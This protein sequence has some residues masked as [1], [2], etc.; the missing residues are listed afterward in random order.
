MAN[1]IAS[2]FMKSMGS[3]IPG[4]NNGESKLSKEDQK[5][6]NA[7]YMYKTITKLKA[8]EVKSLVNAILDSMC[9]VTSNEQV[10]D[11]PHPG[12]ASPTYK[13]IH[14]LA[15]ELT[16]T[17]FSKV[18]DQLNSE[19]STSN[20]QTGGGG[21][22]DGDG[23]FTR[24]AKLHPAVR[25]ASTALGTASTALK[26]AGDMKNKISGAAEKA[27]D[28]IDAVKEKATEVVDTT[29]N[30]TTDAVEKI[31]N[32][33]NLDIGNGI[34]DTTAKQAKDA[35]NTAIQKTKSA[36]Q[37]IQ[38]TL[39]NTDDIQKKFEAT[40]DKTVENTKG[41]AK[42]IQNT[43]V[44]TTGM[45]D[46]ITGV[47]KQTSKGAKDVIEETAE[48]AKVVV[49]QTAEDIANNAAA[50]TIV[51]EGGEKG[52]TEDDEVSD[53]EITEDEVDDDDKESD[54][55]EKTLNHLRKRIIQTIQRG[56]FE[57]LIKSIKI[58]ADNHLKDTD[59]TKKTKFEDIMKIMAE[60]DIK[61]LESHMEFMLY[62]IENSE[63]N[64][65]IDNYISMILVLKHFN[66]NNSF[67]IDVDL[68]KYKLKNDLI[69][70]DDFNRNK[71]TYLQNSKSNLKK[72]GLSS[73][74]NIKDN[75]D[76]TID[77]TKLTELI[78]ESQDKTTGGTRRYKKK[79]K[80][81]TKRHKPKKH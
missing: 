72:Y 52:K 40:V 4:N 11:A 12:D 77:A 54:L 56:G 20:E 75:M 24:I 47:I 41:I 38:K 29:S 74:D 45:K 67:D 69:T 17:I 53:G 28:A 48:D 15:D 36:A 9:I 32:P 68:N 8:H 33:A 37:K 70:E 80:R 78:Q 22:G 76:K 79:G 55:K 18:V 30:F 7:K 57:N 21:G 49:K 64:K 5:K 59:I 58:T 81:L 62:K 34:I 51:T 60:K 31:S 25:T 23:L 71:E 1:I 16:D 43:I 35:G 13:S 27:T 50:G 65:D 6:L 10:N 39:E 26:K 63:N 44:D 46:Q 14:S 3:M 66:K 61:I 73:Y 2:Q 19:E 42:N